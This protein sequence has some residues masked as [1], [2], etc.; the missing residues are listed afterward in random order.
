MQ[1]HRGALTGDEAAV[2]L[3]VTAGTYYK[4]ERGTHR[5]STDTARALAKWLGWTVEQVLDAADQP[6]PPRDSPEQL[7]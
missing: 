5:P 3:H 6:A 4:L 1:L 7:G 2:V